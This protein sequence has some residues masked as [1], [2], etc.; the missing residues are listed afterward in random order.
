MGTWTDDLSVGNAQIDADHKKLMVM[1]DGIE[2][3]IRARDGYAL[4]QALEQLEY[5]LY[6]HFVREEKIAEAIGF[7]FGKN[8]SEHEHVLREFQHM[9]NELIAKE[10]AWSD[11]AAEH[12]SR[13]L[14]G[15][16]SDHI[17]NEDMLLKP[18]LKDH[19]YDFDPT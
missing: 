5:H 14:S 1:V 4:T 3:M 18:A 16:M 17:L 6:L 9:K 11:G 19:P 7:P 13:F 2:A 8:K 12:Y 15:W 10:G